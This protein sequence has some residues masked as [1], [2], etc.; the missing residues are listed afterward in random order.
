MLR[1]YIDFKIFYDRVVDVKQNVMEK[2]SFGLSVKQK[3]VLGEEM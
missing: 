2:V 1:E 3:Y